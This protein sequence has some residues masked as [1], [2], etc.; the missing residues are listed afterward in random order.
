MTEVIVDKVVYGAASH[1]EVQT[2]ADVVKGLGDAVTEV[3]MVV[4]AEADIASLRRLAT[5]PLHEA[6]STGFLEF[7]GMSFELVL[8]GKS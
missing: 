8:A 3:W 5:K 4:D 2:V 1:G 6:L 7:F